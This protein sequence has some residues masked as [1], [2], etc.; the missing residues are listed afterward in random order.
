MT[1]STDSTDSEPIY[2]AEVLSVQRLSP[3][4]VRVTFGGA[5]LATFASSGVGDE[6]LRVFLPHGPDRRDVSLPF[7]TPGGG[8][9][10]PDGT[11]KAPLRTYT[12]RAM[13]IDPVEI[14]LDF[15]IHPGGVAAT[16][17]RDAAR[18]DVV[19]LNRP[20]GLYD[21]PADL[22]WQLL[23]SDQAGLPALGRLLATAPPHV[24]TRAVVEVP[25]A[26]HRIE[27]PT[28]PHIEV[29]W[30][31]GGNG[32][33][34]S[35]LDEVVRSAPAPD[36]DAGSGY[37]WVAGE[38]GCLRSVRKH[39]RRERGLS[40]DRFKVVGYWVV[41]SEEWNSRY[42]ALPQQVRE[43]LLAMWTDESRD[44][45]EVEDEYVDRLERL[46]L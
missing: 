34:P 46:G 37:I 33:A 18:G 21:P 26:D 28:G 11:I 41:E 30:I 23:V 15:V 7:G 10:W 29:T 9:D 5:G 1:D 19:G 17:A 14:D 20:T 13:R 39:L 25:D 44:V 24:R 45:E 4:M 40:A 38:S 43:E 8:W 12:V 16:W 6:Y 42:A 27:L 2:R 22:D 31:D 35:R 3:A 36:G 32:H